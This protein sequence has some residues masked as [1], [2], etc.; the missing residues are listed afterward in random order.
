MQRHT[1]TRAA[2]MLRISQPAM[3]RL[4]G[5]FESSTGLI[6]FDRRQGRLL[7]TREALALFEEVEQSFRG[8]DRIAGAVDQIRN[9]RRGSLRIACSPALALGFLPQM[10][11]AFMDAHGGIEVTML[12]HPAS[13]V[14]DFVAGQRADVGFLQDA[15]THPAVQLERIF[16]GPMACILPPGHWL[17]DREIICPKD[18]ACEVFISF[19]P[20]SDAQIAIDNVF[21][22]AGITRQNRLYVQLAQ[23]AIGLVECGAGVAIADLASAHYAHGRVAVRP[24]H[25]AIPDPI[26]LATT[27]GYP[28]SAL[29]AGFVR[30][31]RESLARGVLN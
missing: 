17:V 24:F 27:V 1:V 2:K 16:E 13:T 30:V 20:Q 22:A 3:S 4:I 23:T 8:L 26:F 9:M 25:P 5:D 29:A 12:E 28:P 7:P 15:I 6:L 21:A 18:L 31:M 10:V 19:P 11:A 14:I